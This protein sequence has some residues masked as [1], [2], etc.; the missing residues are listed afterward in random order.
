MAGV[1]PEQPGQCQRIFL[2]GSAATVA[3]H[4]HRQFTARQDRDLPAFGARLQG[5]PRVV[6]RD[7]AG[8]AFQVGA[9]IDDRIAGLSGDFGGGVERGARPGDQLEARTGKGGIAGLAALVAGILER[10]ADRGIDRKPI[11]PTMARA[12]ASVVGSGTVG[13][14]AM[15]DGSSCGTSD[16]ASVTISARWPARA[17]RPPLIRDK[18]LRTVLTSPIGAPER[19]SARVTC[20]FCA[21]D[22]PAGR[23]DPVGGAAARQQHQQQIVRA[24]GLGETQAVFRALE[25]GFVGHRMAGLDDPD[26]PG[27]QAVA[28]TG[29]RDSRQPRRIETEFVEVMPLRR[30]GH[31]GRGLAGG[32]ADH[33]AFRRGAQMRRK[34]A[35]G[36]RGGNGGVED[37]RSRGRLS[38]IASPDLIGAHAAPVIHRFA[39]KENPRNRMRGNSDTRILGQF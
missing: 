12:S 19:N 22:T 10:A 9:E 35:V 4:G 36:V 38:V 15:A 7:V 23:C 33:P 18:C 25:A 2:V 28:V 34:H 24:G 3:A 30:H 29:G 11:F 32:Q 17:S 1:F 14:D 31:G 13:P 5:E 37:P 16:I 20:C 8:L 27:R 6:G 39:A 21:N 26:T